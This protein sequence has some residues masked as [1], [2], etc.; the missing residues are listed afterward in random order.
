MESLFGASMTGAYSLFGGQPRTILG[1]TGPVLVFER[2]CLNFASKYY[3]L[4]KP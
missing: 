3:I 4:F 1:S 2:F